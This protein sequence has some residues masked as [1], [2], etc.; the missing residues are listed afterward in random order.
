MIYTF[1]LVFLFILL[2]SFGKVLY[3][4]VQISKYQGYNYYD[5]IQNKD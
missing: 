3:D 2:L 1:L 4:L 5:Y